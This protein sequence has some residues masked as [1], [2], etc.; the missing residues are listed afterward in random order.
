MSG[1]E[2]IAARVAKEFKDGDYVNLGIGLPTM[3]ANFIPQDIHVTMHAE[4][5]ILGVGPTPDC[6]NED[7]DCTDAGGNFVT[8]LNGAAF[9]DSALSFALIRGAHLDITVLGALEVD[10]EGNLASWMVPGKKVTGMG[11]AMDLVVGAKKV[12]IAM[13]HVNKDGAPKILHKCKLPLTAVNEVDLIVTDMAVIEVVHGR[14]LLLKEIAP[15]KTIEEVKQ[16]TGADLMLAP[17]VKVMMDI[18]N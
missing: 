17:N 3:V 9:I 11:G 16:A 4:N 18:R 2:L 10:Q 7:K 1:R 13:E 6:G 12:I 15:G 8:A 14:G 5:G